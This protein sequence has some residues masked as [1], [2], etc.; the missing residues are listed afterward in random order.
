M[1]F[2]S[3]VWRKSSFSDHNG[4]CVEVA[5]VGAAVRFRDSKD[6]GSPHLTVGS[7]GWA[8]FLDILRSGRC[9]QN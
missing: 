8:T 5:L 1:N 7:A 2:G 9:H 6:T 3:A 4:S